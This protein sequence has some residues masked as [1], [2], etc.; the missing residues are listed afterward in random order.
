MWLSQTMEH[1]K[2]NAI[3]LLVTV[4]DSWGGKTVASHNINDNLGYRNI[5]KLSE[6]EEGDGGIKWEIKGILSL[7]S[8]H[9]ATSG[10][11]KA[12]IRAE[13][14]WIFVALCNTSEEGQ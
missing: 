7:Y 4:H 5:N 9:L 6:Q 3:E 11:S 8:K 14:L 13:L 2:N 12:I 1:A 10:K